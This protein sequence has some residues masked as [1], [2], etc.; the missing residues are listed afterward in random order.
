VFRARIS[1][2]GEVV[3]GL[4]EPSSGNVYVDPVPNLVDTLIHELL[5]RRYPR[6]GEKRVSDTA[7]RLTMAM[8]DDERRAWYRAYQR[9]AKR[10]SKPVH[11][12]A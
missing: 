5:H 6:W 10:L 12:E 3:E 8:S 9:A 1:S 7:H 2:D 11:V 4:Y